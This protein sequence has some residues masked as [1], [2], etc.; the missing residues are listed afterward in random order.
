MTD[1]DEP[2]VL[3]LMPVP[4]SKIIRARL[5]LIDLLSVLAKPDLSVRD[6]ATYEGQA[7]NTLLWL[8]GL[9]SVW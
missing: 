4:L 1:F 7:R 5:F 8:G 6:R 3:V 2:F 9:G